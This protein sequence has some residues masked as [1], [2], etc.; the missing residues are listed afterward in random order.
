VI[1]TSKPAVWLEEKG[2]VLEE[3]YAELLKNMRWKFYRSTP[4]GNTDLPEK[5]RL[6]IRAWYLNYEVQEMICLHG[7]GRGRDH[8]SFWFGAGQLLTDYGA[9]PYRVTHYRDKS[10]K[11]ERDCGSILVSD[12]EYEQHMA[13]L[14]T[15][16]ITRKGDEGEKSPN[17]SDIL[18]WLA[19]KK[20]LYCEIERQ[21]SQADFGLRRIELATNE[22]FSAARA[23]VRAEPV[24]PGFIRKFLP[25]GREFDRHDEELIL[26]IDYL[27]E[28]VWYVISAAHPERRRR[29]PPV[30]LEFVVGP[31]GLISE[32]QSKKWIEKGRAEH[33]LVAVPSSK[34]RA[35]LA[36][37][38]VV[39]FLGLCEKPSIG[40][41]W[42]G[43]DGSR[44]DYEP[45][46]YEGTE[47]SR[48][49]DRKV[50]DVAWKINWPSGTT[51]SGVKRSIGSGPG[52]GSGGKGGRHGA[53][54]VTVG[55]CSVAKSVKETDLRLGIQVNKG[56]YE[57]VTFQ[58]IS[59]VPGEERG[60]EIE[61]GK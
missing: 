21:F 45:W 7:Y 34:W 19:V 15:R 41:R 37:G 20:W 8:M 50:F 52:G 44:L 35:P 51:Q 56:N 61:F 18:N 23:S 16:D 13:L 10:S 22:D 3:N 32:P 57:W 40:S 60:F 39:E 1:D 29:K 9:G 31:E 33:P 47:W 25:A 46:F 54:D 42:W 36:N 14:A 11:P 53:F 30:E 4:E 58:N 59:L 27:G 48:R 2:K 38:V 5:V 28:G 26:K 49:D 12:E 24:R 17:G 55:R 43:P 6:K